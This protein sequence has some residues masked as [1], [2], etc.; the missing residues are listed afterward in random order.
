MTFA[1][2]P[3]ATGPVFEEKYGREGGVFLRIYAD[4]ACD[5]Q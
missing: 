5:L 1:G 2:P 4:S 3:N